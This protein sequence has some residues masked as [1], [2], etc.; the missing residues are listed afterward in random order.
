MCQDDPPG[1]DLT[2]SRTKTSEGM[3]YLGGSVCQKK[4]PANFLGSGSKVYGETTCRDK[5]WDNDLS[6]LQCP[7]PGTLEIILIA[8]GSAL[9]VGI[10]VGVLAFIGVQRCKKRRSEANE[11]EKRRNEHHFNLGHDYP[12]DG[13]QRV[14]S[15]SSSQTYLP[16]PSVL[17]Y[18]LREVPRVPIREDGRP[19]TRPNAAHNFDER[20]FHGEIER[21]RG[22]VERLEKEIPR[23]VELRST[24]RSR[25]TRNPAETRMKYI[26]VL[27]SKSPSVNA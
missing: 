16:G 12:E 14:A 18:G 10:I 8:C 19:N 26:D 4:C 6:D 22:E 15:W 2:C 17:P 11:E 21:L 5:K 27:R 25:R 23:A 1:S 9:V 7:S 13:R 24:E 3:G 20:Q